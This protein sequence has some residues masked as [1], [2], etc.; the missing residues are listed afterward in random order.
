MKLRFN[1]LIALCLVLTSLFCAQSWCA[2]KQ[3]RA[4]NN[5][6]LWKLKLSHKKS[7]H[8]EI[9]S[10]LTKEFEDRYREVFGQ[11]DSDSI[12]YQ[13]SALNAF[14]ENRGVNKSVEQ[15]NQLRRAF[16][17]YMS[18]RLFEYHVDQYMRTQ[19]QLRPMIELKEQIQNVEVEVNDSIRL[20]TQYHFASNEMDVILENPWCESKLTFQM[21]S[22]SIGPGETEEARLRLDKDLDSNL[23]LSTNTAFYDR[24]FQTELIRH[25]EKMHFSSSVGLATPFSQNGRSVRET[26]MLVGFIHSW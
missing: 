21:N 24:T 17:E 13:Q 22:A 25:F 2:K 19:P 14:D 15:R 6:D 12:V 10:P 3:N 23:K 8:D 5:Q 1:P 4:S 18:R 20:N 26:K 16:A 9:F 7:L 11:L